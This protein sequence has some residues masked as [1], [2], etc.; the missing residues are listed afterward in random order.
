MAVLVEED[1]ASLLVGATSVGRGSIEMDI[2]CAMID[3]VP[4]GEVLFV[5]I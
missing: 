3:F 2:R 5:W 1:T 4:R